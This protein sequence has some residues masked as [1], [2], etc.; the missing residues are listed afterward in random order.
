MPRPIRTGLIALAAVLLAG[1]PVL[2]APPDQAEEKG[3]LGERGDRAAAMMQRVRDKLMEGITL[4]DEQ[5]EQA[6]AIVDEH[7]AAWD[8]WREE[9]GEAMQE[10]R[11]KMRE[12]MKDRDREKMAELRNEVRELMADA[13]KPMDMLQS[14]RDEVLDAGQQEQFDANLKELREARERW[15]KRMRDRARDRDGVRDGSG[16]DEGERKRERRRDRAGDG[17]D[18]EGGG[19]EDTNDSLDI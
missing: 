19:D 5:K 1:P 11:L 4:T 8:A 10:L 7:R 14:I 13:P 3:P 12:A 16:G 15:H 2:A 18:T 6:V 17:D 9:H